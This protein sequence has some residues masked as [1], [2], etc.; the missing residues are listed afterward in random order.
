M[1]DERRSGKREEA[2]IVVQ[3]DDMGS[4]GVTRD[5]SDK[6]LLIATRHAFATGDLIDVTVLAPSGQVDRIGRVVRVERTPPT[7]EWPFRVAVELDEPLPSAAITDG[8]K[9]AANLRPAKK[10]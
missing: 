1:A 6:G 2:V 8:L 5:M 9:V 10:G 3:F 7:E 4:Y